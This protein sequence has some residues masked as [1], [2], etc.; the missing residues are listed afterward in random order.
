MTSYGLHDFRLRRELVGLAL[1]IGFLLSIAINSP[2]RAAGTSELTNSTAIVERLHA[3]LLDVMKAASTLKA[4]GRFNRLKPVVLDVYSMVKMLQLTVGSKW[5]KAQPDQR[6]RLLSAFSDINIGTYA[7]QFNGY[8]GERFKTIGA[9]PGPRETV[10]VETQILR[11]ED[12]PIRLTYVTLKIERKW[13]IVDVLL[14]NA[15]SQLAIRRSEYRGTLQRDGID[16][17]ISALRKKAN[18]IIPH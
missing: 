16:G 14:N 5:S 9:R 12:T 2:A 3:S 15:I 13:K 4:V 17:L 18:Q 7:R 1:C 8:S 11:R 6:A 10:L